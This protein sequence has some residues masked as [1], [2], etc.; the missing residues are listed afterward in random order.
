M[1]SER[2]TQLAACRNRKLKQKL[3]NVMLIRI[4]KT[5]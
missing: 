1:E 2:A 5:I 3:E 4:H